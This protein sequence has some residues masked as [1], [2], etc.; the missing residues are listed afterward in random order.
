M[1][2][3]DST[4]PAI[5]LTTRI[6]LDEGQRSALRDAFQRTATPA[7]TAIPNRGISVLTAVRSTVEAELAMD[8]MTF[9]SLI[10]SRESLALPLALRLQRVLG[11]ELV[12]E[13]DLKAAYA[14]YIAYLKDQHGLQ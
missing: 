10:N 14:S 12:S 1:T 2:S 7:D 8:K 9:S 6:R 4:I 3:F 11:V 5:Q 13:K